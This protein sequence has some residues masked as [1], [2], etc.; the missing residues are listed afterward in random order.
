MEYS[1]VGPRLLNLYTLFTTS[2][3]NKT[4][5]EGRSQII[6]RLV[7]YVA[8]MRFQFSIVLLLSGSV[9]LGVC[10]KLLNEI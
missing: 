5:E 2:L 9:T 7:I 8:T 4:N 1:G 3:N 10:S 6:T